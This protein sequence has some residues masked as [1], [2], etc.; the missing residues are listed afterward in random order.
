M[1]EEEDRIRA[2]RSQA[3]QFIVQFWKREGQNI[4]QFDQMTD[5]LAEFA[6]SERE[7]GRREGIEQ[8]RKCVDYEMAECGTISRRDSC[9]N[10]LTALRALA[11]K[12]GS[13]V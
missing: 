13:Q 11:D 5:M 9:D 2:E 12:E 1:T 10:I 6:R 7:A 3:Q 4:L 8:A